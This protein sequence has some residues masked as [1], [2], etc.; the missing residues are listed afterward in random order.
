MFHYVSRSY[1]FGK[2]FDYFIHL[3]SVETIQ[4]CEGEK[5]QNTPTVVSLPL[6]GNYNIKHTH[7]S[8]INYSQ[9]YLKPSLQDLTNYSTPELS[10]TVHIL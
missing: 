10:S 8:T 3:I 1:L 7:I 6:E 9:N 5:T 4:N 2:C